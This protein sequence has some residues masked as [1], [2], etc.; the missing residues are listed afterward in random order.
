MAHY[1]FKIALMDLGVL[2]P[3]CMDLYP[4]N[5]LCVEHPIQRLF[6]SLSASL[7][8]WVY[9]GDALGAFAH[10]PPPSI[11][12]YPSIDDDDA[13]G[14]FEKLVINSTALKCSL[15][16]MVTLS[17]VNYGQAISN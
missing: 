2:L 11:S 14:T 15:F 9:G 17:Q 7:G 3:S 13:N 16:C 6:F 10:S 4:L 1:V 12:S 5:S 8:Y